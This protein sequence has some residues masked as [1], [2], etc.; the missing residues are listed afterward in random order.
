MMG[1]EILFD[2]SSDLTPAL[3]MKYSSSSMANIVEKASTTLLPACLFDYT[4]QQIF[5][6]FF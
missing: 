1:I 5:N 6:R 2:Y 4:G 3:L